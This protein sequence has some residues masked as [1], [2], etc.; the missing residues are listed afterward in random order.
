[1]SALIGPIPGATVTS[2]ELGLLRSGSVRLVPVEGEVYPGA[3]P[4]FAYWGW[5]S[6][7]T[8][9]SGLA[10][11]RIVRT[12]ETLGVVSVSPPNNTGYFGGIAARDLPL[13][14][15]SSLTIAL[16]GVPETPIMTAPPISVSEGNGAS[17]VVQV[18]VSLSADSGLTKGV[19]WRTYD[20]ADQPAE[21]ADYASASG[22]IWFYGTSATFPV[23]ING[24]ALDEPDEILYILFSEPENLQLGGYGITVIRI[25]DDDPPPRVLPGGASVGEGDAG[26]TQAELPVTLSAASGR[27][28]TVEWSTIRPIAAT[29]GFADL[30]D[31]ADASEVVTFAPGE[32]AKSVSVTVN[33]DVTDEPDEL[34]VVSFRNP[35]NATMGGFWGLGFGSITDDD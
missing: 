11:L 27:S 18:P 22:N 8:D 5:R 33:G 12:T 14:T 3:P 25:V 24:D 9:G 21:G 19:R 29:P 7:V 34:V 31:Y 2:T 10:S 30:D 28:V 13:T 6:V 17:K 32:T 15:D 20:E 16:D 26:T 1:M 35:T 4:S 23:T